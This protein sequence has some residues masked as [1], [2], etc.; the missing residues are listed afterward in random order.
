MSK[1]ILIGL[2]GLLGWNG[3]IGLLLILRLFGLICESSQIYSK[4]AKLILN[5]P[6]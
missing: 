6:N 4:S 3:L 1:Y 5:Q 2:N